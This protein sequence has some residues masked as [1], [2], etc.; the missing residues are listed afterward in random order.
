MPINVPMD[1]LVV[2]DNSGDIELIQEGF[3]RGSTAPNVHVLSDGEQVLPFLRGEGPY[4]GA[5]TPDLI[6]LDLN[7]PG[8][9][10]REVLMEVKSDP[11]FKQ[12]PVVIMTAS[13]SPEDIFRAYASHAN[14]YLPKPVD[15]KQFLAVIASIKE[16]WLTHAKPPAR[17]RC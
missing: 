10:G 17:V 12:I 15:L 13:E 6:L 4:S 9:D 11:E 2:E 8:K 7:L 1:V 3:Q 5:P 16:L 14:C